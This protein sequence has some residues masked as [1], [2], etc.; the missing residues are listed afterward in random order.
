[1]E[2]DLSKSSLSEKEKNDQLQENIGTDELLAISSTQINDKVTLNIYKSKSS[3]QLYVGIDHFHFRNEEVMF[4]LETF[5]KIITVIE[6]QN[7]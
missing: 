6:A 3:D 5:K 2:I 1:M 7:L 4:K